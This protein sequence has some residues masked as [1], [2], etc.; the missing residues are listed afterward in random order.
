[1]QTGPNRSR[2]FTLIELLVVIAI[3]GILAGM[4]L[5]ALAKAKASAVRAQCVNHLKQ[6]GLGLTMYAGDNRDFFPDNTGAPAQDTAWMANT[7]TNFYSTYLYPNRPG[8]SV[9]QQR[10]KNDVIYC[11]TDTWHRFYEGSQL[12]ANL[13]G[14]NYLPGRLAN[15]GVSADYN[16]YGLVEWFTRKK[17]NG[18]YRK[19]P[20]I[21]DK[22]Q[23]HSDGN[24]TT[25]FNGQ[26][27]PDSSHRGKNN[28]PEGGNFCYEDGHVQWRT[29]KYVSPGMAAPV[30]QIQVGTGTPNYYQFLRPSEL[31]KGPW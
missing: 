25:T 29:F 15:G 7:F 2:A 23:Q 8:T 28:V 6:W 14:Y 12:T 5:P 18:P 9:S 30:S 16:H 1:M 26:V 4:L 21:M 22:L 3:I 11:P 17:M 20:T 31:D 24:W 27:Q 10:T 19:A 13:I